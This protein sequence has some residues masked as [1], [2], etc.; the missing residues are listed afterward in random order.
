MQQ[1][2]DFEGDGWSKKVEGSKPNVET[3]AAVL[4]IR[5]LK[6]EVG[7]LKKLV[8]GLKGEVNGGS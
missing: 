7:E 4:E 8:E 1:S 3:D 5:G 6:E 2:C